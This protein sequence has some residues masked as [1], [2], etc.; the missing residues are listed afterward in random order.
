VL[1]KETEADAIVTFLLDM[2][3]I[4]ELTGCPFAYCAVAK[5]AFET[6][7]LF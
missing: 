2:L 1:D 3:P 5:F 7:Q 6:V 4:L